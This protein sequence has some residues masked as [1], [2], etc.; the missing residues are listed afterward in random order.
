MWCK[1]IQNKGLQK[2]TGLGMA[3]QALY[4]SLSL[5]LLASAGGCRQLGYLLYLVV[6]GSQTKTVEA[7][8]DGLAGKTVV[9]I[10]F[11]DQEVQ[12]EYPMARWELSSVIASELDKHVKGVKVVNPRR[13]TRYQD[14]DIFW[15][16]LS[17]KDLGR[18][19]GA[20][21]VLYIAML[22]F[23]TR[24]LGSVNLYRGRITAEC[25]VYDCSLPER[26][27]RVW[28]DEQI[29]VVYPEN[30]PTGQLDRDDRKV[31]YQSQCLFADRL[32]KNFYKHKVP[33][34]K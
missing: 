25:S 12:Y 22:E 27:A 31:R 34:Y 8:F 30:V 29:R 33:K 6:P 9:V 17:K 1:A 24:E 4:W 10:V 20:D 19:F 16:T 7:A 14:E 23:S 18:A 28:S 2:G 15:D 3:G 5:A 32:V 11:T 13:I 26:Q 21:F